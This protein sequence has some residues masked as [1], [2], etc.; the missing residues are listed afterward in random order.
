[1]FKITTCILF[2]LCKSSCL[3]LNLPIR[4]SNLLNPIEILNK[5]IFNLEHNMIK[6]NSNLKTIEK[7]TK[8]VETIG[9]EK[10][11][12]KIEKIFV[13]IDSIEENDIILDTIFNLIS[14]PSEM[15]SFINLLKTFPLLFIP[16][17]ILY[18]EIILII[19]LL[20]LILFSKK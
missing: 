5:T 2:V 3:T 1:M 8:T 9:I 20:L 16:L 19:I 10:I 6:F 12:K 17:L 11:T 4:P 15:L 14:K 13:I 18:F 7:L